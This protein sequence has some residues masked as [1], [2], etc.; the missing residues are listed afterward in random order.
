MKSNYFI[1]LLILITTSCEPLRSPYYKYMSSYTPNTD[2]EIYCPNFIE[3]QK[4]DKNY[5]FLYSFIV[6]K[7]QVEEVRK[8]IENAAE[9]RRENK[10]ND[11]FT[12]LLFDN[13]RSVMLQG[14]TPEKLLFCNLKQV[15]NK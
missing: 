4:E 8:A 6:L 2:T 3:H 7:S 5:R 12:V 9:I 13:Y 14:I 15:F 11:D 1:I 10:S